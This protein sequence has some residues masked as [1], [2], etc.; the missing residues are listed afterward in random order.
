MRRLLCWIGWHGDLY[1][2]YAVYR[3]AYCDEVAR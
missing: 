3:C 1:A 2:D